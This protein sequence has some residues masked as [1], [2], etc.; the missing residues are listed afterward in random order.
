[1]C[2]SICQQN[3]ENQVCISLHLQA[4]QQCKR[5]TAQVVYLN[6]RDL[7]LAVLVYMQEEQNCSHKTWHIHIEI[8]SNGYS[9]IS[10]KDTQREK[11]PSNKTPAFSK[12]INMDIR[13]VGT[14]NQFF[15]TGS[16]TENKLDT[17]KTPFF[18][19]GPCCTPH[20]I[21]L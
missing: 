21:C 17:G 9:R 4:D 15:I 19:I 5:F 6:S 18:V 14:S 2:R 7:F 20:T 3:T 1:M 16:Y 8:I 10:F 12:S 13:V 11:A